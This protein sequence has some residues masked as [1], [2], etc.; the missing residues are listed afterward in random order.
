MLNKMISCNRTTMKEEN[1]MALWSFVHCLD[2]M[3]KNGLYTVVWEGLFEVSFK[4]RHLIRSTQA[5]L[6]IYIYIYGK[7]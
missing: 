5:M 2:K 7:V 1:K 4:L 6:A 3:K